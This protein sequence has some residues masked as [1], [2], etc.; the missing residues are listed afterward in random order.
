[1]ELCQAHLGPDHPETLTTNFK[2]AEAYTGFRLPAA[3]TLF[4]QV[5]EKRRS[6]LGPDHELTLLTLNSLGESCRRAGQ[7]DRAA[8]LIEE[9]LDRKTAALRPGHPYTANSIHDLG[10]VYRDMGQYAKAIA[11]LEEATDKLAVSWGPD[12]IHT[13][14][15]RA[16]L[17]EV[18]QSTGRLDDANRVLREIIRRIPKEDVQL[19]GDSANE[20]A[21][22]GQNLLQL[23]RPAE[24]E[25]VLRESLAIFD[26]MKASGPGMR[27]VQSLLGEALLD[28]QQ[29]AAAEP[30]L[31]QGYE[32]LKRREATL[33]ENQ[34]RWLADAGQRVVRFY[35]A[36]NQPQKAGRLREELGASSGPK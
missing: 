36:T 18:Y 1:V 15:S 31:L 23:K 21:L 27:H 12:H 7:L 14:F 20:R 26:K 28:Q 13:R 5:L 2:L 8:L 9:S 3:I 19:L 16:N 25:V 10:L 30:L 33:T 4:E 29:Q 22:L 34:K 17:A 11:L 24:A 35:E 32:G 6:L